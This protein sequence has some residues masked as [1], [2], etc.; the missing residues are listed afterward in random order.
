MAM[1]K[2]AII[3]AAM[4]FIGASHAHH[5]DAG[6]DEDHRSLYQTGVPSG[7]QKRVVERYRLAE[8][9]KTIELEFTLEDP[10]TFT[11]PA[12]IAGHWLALG[13]EIVPYECDL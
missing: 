7:G 10:E 9:G 6:L 1:T 5:S 8:D 4:I 3:L 11:E 13:E 12:T 2:Y